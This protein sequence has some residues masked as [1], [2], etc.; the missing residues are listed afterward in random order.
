MVAGYVA[1]YL[2]QFVDDVI[3]GVPHHWAEVR[4]GVGHDEPTEIWTRNVVRSPRVA[5][6]IS[7]FHAVCSGR[8]ADDPRGRIEG[9][10]DVGQLGPRVAPDRCQ[11]ALVRRAQGSQQY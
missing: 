11:N 9:V 3:V 8:D 7:R 4:R 2:R 1:I 5:L 10:Y 6:K